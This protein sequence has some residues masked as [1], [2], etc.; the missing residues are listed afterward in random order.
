VAALPAPAI[1]AS[2][3]SGRRVSV[4]CKA[5]VLFAPR[6][7]GNGNTIQGFLFLIV[8][9]NG[10]RKSRVER[11]KRALRIVLS[12]F[13]AS[14]LPERLN[15]LPHSTAQPSNIVRSVVSGA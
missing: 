5:G 9:V 14:Q 13:G 4:D 10:Q 3:A 12:E 1:L 7:R 11:I 8:R 15:Q 2:A 6:L